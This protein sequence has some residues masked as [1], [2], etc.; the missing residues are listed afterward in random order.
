MTPSTSGVSAQ[1]TAAIETPQPA[2]VEIL[3]RLDLGADIPALAG[4]E[5]K[6]QFTTYAPGAV[7]TPHS[8]AGKV[9]VVHVLSGAVI[10]HHRDGRRIAYAA[11]DT[12][13]ANKDTVH[14]LENRGDVPACLMVAMIT[15]QP[16]RDEHA[17]RLRRPGGASA[18]ASNTGFP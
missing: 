18:P 3:G 1:A 16:A 6:L 7:G 2:T 9:E 12:F 17:A 15:D 4:K 11:G 5:L 8:H 13:T 14:H 10:E